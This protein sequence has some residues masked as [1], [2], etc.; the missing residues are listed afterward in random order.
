MLCAEFKLRFGILVAG[1]VPNDQTA[2]AVLLAGVNL[3]GKQGGSAF[4]LPSA[5]WPSGRQ[6]SAPD[7]ASGYPELRP[8]SA[9]Q[10]VGP[11]RP[12]KPALFSTYGVFGRLGRSLQFW[13]FSKQPAHARFCQRP[14]PTICVVYHLWCV[15]RP[16]PRAG[17]RRVCDGAGA[18][19][20]AV[21]PKLAPDA[22][23]ATAPLSWQIAS[24]ALTQVSRHLEGGGEDRDGGSGTSAAF[25]STAAKLVRATTL[26]LANGVQMHASR[27]R[28][29]EEADIG[30][31]SSAAA[32]KGDSERSARCCC[33]RWPSVGAALRCGGRKFG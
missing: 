17:I 14:R 5:S 15:V 22:R 13:P 23:R 32:P 10:P 11:S 28:S 26:A 20:G 24:P 25:A 2:A 1:F 30:R 21:G 3:C 16:A 29:S 19:V 9:N 31:I 4:S 12:A 8:A 33:T 18:A 7:H 6:L 27:A